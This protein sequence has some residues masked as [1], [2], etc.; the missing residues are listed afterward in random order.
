ML[1]GQ[2]VTIE[3]CGTK[4]GHQYQ[5]LGHSVSGEIVVEPYLITL[6]E[7]A[8]PLSLPK[9]ISARSDGE[10]RLAQH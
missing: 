9:T 10:V 3:S 1:A 6:T 2:G 5:L 4:A 8:K 7:E